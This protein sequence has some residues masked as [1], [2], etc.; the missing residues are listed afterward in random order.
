[1]TCSFNCSITRSRAE[2][3]ADERR[4]FISMSL[5]QSGMHTQTPPWHAGHAWLVKA[6]TNGWLCILA[7][8]GQRNAWVEQYDCYRLAERA[9]QTVALYRCYMIVKSY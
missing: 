9:W 1:M 6:L 2:A 5:S 7:D 3:P 4:K 8:L